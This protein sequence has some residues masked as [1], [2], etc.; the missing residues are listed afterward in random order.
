MATLIIN[1]DDLKN[2]NSRINTKN[3]KGGF[4]SYNL[5]DSLEFK[6]I[7]VIMYREGN[8]DILIKSPNKE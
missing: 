2:L 4:K 7:D 6:D 5:R 3:I 1:A 8:K